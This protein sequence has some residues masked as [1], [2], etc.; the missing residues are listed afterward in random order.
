MSNN[1]IHKRVLYTADYIEYELVEKFN[2]S[3]F[4]AIQLEDSTDIRNSAILLIYVLYIDNKF[5]NT[6]EKFLRTLKLE[7]YTISDNI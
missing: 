5:D 4:Y 1:T 2:K 3:L 7:T 6:K